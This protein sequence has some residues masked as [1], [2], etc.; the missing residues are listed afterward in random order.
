MDSFN[1]SFVGN[2][3]V[4]QSSGIDPNRPSM[5]A[6][7]VQNDNVHSSVEFLRS[8]SDFIPSKDDVKGGHSE[9]ISVIHE[10]QSI[11]NGH[12]TSQMDENQRDLVEHADYIPQVILPDSS[13][14]NHGHGERTVGQMRNVS[15]PE[16]FS[17][18]QGI[19]NS[20]ADINQNQYI[21]SKHCVKPGKHG[22]V[23]KHGRTSDHLPGEHIIE[24]ETAVGKYQSDPIV[25]NMSDKKSPEKW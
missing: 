18:P 3:S 21:S 13:E 8:R 6:N 9:H 15:N 23:Q 11:E 24:P 19:K 10:K 2:H 7:F 22:K 4:Y 25:F 12:H 5:D 1:H 17:G 14:E 16:F 20:A